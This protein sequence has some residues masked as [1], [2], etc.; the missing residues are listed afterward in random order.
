MDQC[1]LQVRRI[2]LKI[3]RGLSS[4]DDD[5]FFSPP[6]GGSKSVK[7]ISTLILLTTNKYNCE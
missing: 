1:A 6:N 4:L 5:T 7:K 2:S 3:S